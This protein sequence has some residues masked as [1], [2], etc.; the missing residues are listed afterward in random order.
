MRLALGILGGVAAGF[1]LA[2]LINSTPSGRRA[3]AG[4]NATMDD[5]A[6]AVRSGYRARVEELESAI[7]EGDTALR[8][9]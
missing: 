1:V 8:A 7:R 4:V 9:R 3:F 2:H 6:E 5:V